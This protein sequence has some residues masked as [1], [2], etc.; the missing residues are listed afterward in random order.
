LLIKLNILLNRLLNFIV[1]KKSNLLLNMILGIALII[2]VSSCKDDTVVPPSEGIP[3]ADG[4]Y[5]TQEGV[6]PVPTAQL[7]TAKVDA[8]DFGAMDRE[9]FVQGYAY[10]TAG[11]YNMV[12][13][14]D[15]AIINTYG[16]PSQAITDGNAECDVTSFDLIAA[17]VDGA[18]FTIA[19][20]GLYVMAYDATQGEIIYD[21]IVSAGIIGAAT[22]GGWIDDTQMIA[23][24]T[25]ESANFTLEGVII[26]VGQMKFR[27]NC[28]W[29]IDRRIDKGLNFD[30]ANGYSL[31][32]NFGNTIDN[33]LPGNEGPNI[34]VA[35]YAIYTV[36]LTM[37]FATGLVTSTLT[38]TG[39]APPKAQYPDVMYLVGAGTA[40]G[41]DA[42]STVANA[43]MHKIAGGVEGI[44][45][46]ILHLEA[47]QGFKI[48]AANWGEP[49]LGF[50]QVDE[51]DVNGVT[52]TD[53]GGNMDIPV[54]G[55]YMVVLDLQN[56]LKKVSIVA[57]KV[58]G[59]GDAFGGW[60]EAMA[61]SIYTVDDVAKTITSPAFVADH[62]AVRSYVSHA[63]IPAWWNAEFVVVSSAIEYRND[64]ASDPTA[65]PVTAGQVMSFTFDDNTGSIN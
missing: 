18:T 15:K 44:Y 20:D 16:G 36:T 23:Q 56:S 35:E 19:T 60:D 50:A 54:S 46:K 64:S 12:E 63:W 28:R 53:S 48:A 34:E 61:A 51:Y 45:W 27:F 30:N 33:L 38:K 9:G 47:G 26:D 41:W 39:E 11:T 55:M 21:E 57:P 31:F 43:E 22:P 37:D 3:V 5:F 32:T 4:F 42:P 6:D 7:T 24:I 59:I 49:N 1:M 58:Y 65:V 40:Y 8:P 2:G 52:V 17:T 14:K 25:A 62:A 13:I 10:L 29:A